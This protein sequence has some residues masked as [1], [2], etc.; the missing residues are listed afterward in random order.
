MAKSLE[1]VS[2]KN[3]EY[4]SEKGQPHK[5][6]LSAWQ[7]RE[8]KG[9]LRP[10]KLGLLGGLW[11]WDWESQSGAASREAQ[12]PNGAGVAGLMEPERSFP[13][14]PHPALQ[15]GLGGPGPAL[16]D[17]PD[18]GGAGWSQRR[19]QRWGEGDP[20]QLGQ[21]PMI[22]VAQLL[23]VF[24]RCPHPTPRRVGR[25]EEERGDA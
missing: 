6:G 14:S 5:G 9:K 23:E 11:K 10:Q 18:V 20:R 25:A 21:K 13:K 15:S 24:A 1:K 19:L 17:P 22:T 12:V 8:E 16:P 7:S 3:G 4:V 2:K